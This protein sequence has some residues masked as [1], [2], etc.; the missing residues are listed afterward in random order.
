LNPALNTRTAEGLA[1]EISLSFQYVLIQEKISNLYALNNLMYEATF[2]R[3]ARDVLLQTAG[4][5][6]APQYWQ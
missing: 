6:G 1:L 4:K 2:V 5:Y 3:I